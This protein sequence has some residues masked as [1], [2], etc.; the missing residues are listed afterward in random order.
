[1]CDECIVKCYSVSGGRNKQQQ[2]L[3]CGFWAMEIHSA[4]SPA[5]AVSFSLTPSLQ[6]LRLPLFDPS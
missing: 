3:K 5:S 4:R 2:V 1:M 6:W